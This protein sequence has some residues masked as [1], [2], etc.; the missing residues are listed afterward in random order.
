M[1][2]LKLR[3]NAWKQSWSQLNRIKY[4]KPNIQL[5]PPTRWIFT[6]VLYLLWRNIG[7]LVTFI[8]L[9]LLMN[10]DKNLFLRVKSEHWNQIKKKKMCN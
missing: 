7:K 10:L 1:E 5:T 9:S 4:L 8:N 6:I 3:A 2:Q